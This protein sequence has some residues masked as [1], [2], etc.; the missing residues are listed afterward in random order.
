MLTLDQVLRKPWLDLDHFW[1]STGWSKMEHLGEVEI[2]DL[3]NF[4]GYV[5]LVKGL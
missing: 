1:T 3:I 2:M 4:G 5:D